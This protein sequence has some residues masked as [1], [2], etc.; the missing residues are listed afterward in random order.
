MP[1]N[2]AAPAPPN[3]K[4]KGDLKERLQGMIDRFNDLKR[5]VETAD[6]DRTELR[7][8]LDALKAELTKWR[9]YLSRASNPIRIP[10]VE[11]AVRDSGEVIGFSL[12]RAMH[13]EF[14]M[15]N[16]KIADSEEVAYER[17]GAGYEREVFQEMRKRDASLAD[18][19]NL[20]FLVP[21]QVME[22]IIEKLRT[23][24]VL[25]SIGL[26]MVPGFDGGSVD[27]PKEIEDGNAGWLPES[28]SAAATDQEVGF[29]RMT[30]K[31]SYALRKVQ[32]RLL[33]TGGSRVETV[34][35]RAMLARL[36]R[37]QQ[38]AVFQGSGNGGA[39]RGI[40]NKAGINSQD[41]STLT[42]NALQNMIKKIQADDA[43]TGTMF[44]VMHTLA[45]WAIYQIAASDTTHR[46]GSPIFTQGDPSKGEP[47]TILG[48]PFVTTNDIT[49]TGGTSTDILLGVFGNAILGMW[50]DV[51]VEVNTQAA[52]P[53][54]NR[55]TWFLAHQ[56]VDVAALHEE[57][58]CIGTS[59]T[60]AA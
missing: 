7:Q 54:L 42:V 30:P 5:S 32:N 58:F 51:R 36:L 35:R 27:W 52:T 4:P 17:A 10:G 29:V 57:S 23:K 59:M 12:A 16:P 22:D 14:R 2:P 33:T 26:M 19:S 45:K 25:D 20:G 21:A 9:G 39:P 48:I 38:S 15:R 8:E 31:T 28:A 24:L 55:Q 43:D 34:L 3:N 13:A 40:M 37:V 47:P 56:D 6:G 49:V 18:D 50:G 44:W 46:Q 41:L 1:D 60:V 53:F 11:S